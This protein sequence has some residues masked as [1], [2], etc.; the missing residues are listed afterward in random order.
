MKIGIDLRCLE[1]EKISGVGEYALEIVRN[2]LE[3][4]TENQYIIFSNSY[5]QKS[6]NFNFLKRYPR[7]QLKRF[8][9]PN[10]VLNL[11]LW[12]FGWPKLDRLVGGADIFFAPNINFLSVGRICKLVTT[13][14]DL[15]FERF[16]EF[17]SLKTRLWHYFF[18]NPRRIAKKAN[19]I[20]AVSRSTRN[21]LKELYKTKSEAISIIHHGISENYTVISRNNPKLLD[22][23]K[24]YSL[25]YKFILYLGNIEPR[26]N[27]QSIIE[28]YKKVRREHPDLEKHKLVLAGNIS[29]LC[30]NI[31]EK[32]KENIIAAGYVD[33]EDKPFIYNLAS[34]FVYL[35]LFEGFGLPVLEAMACG[36]PA[37]TSNNSSIP[38]VAGNAAILVDPSRPQEISEAIYSVLSGDKLYNEMRKRGIRQAKK[39]SWP[40][41]A[42]ETSGIFRKIIRS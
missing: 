33:Q 3:A 17:F 15:S 28:A 13:F 39:F 6:Q 8:R 25:P 20:I 32:E 12:Y 23:Q 30:Y 14:H 42:E 21:D 27:I 1:E 19:R 34:L 7:A 31:V 35:S 29:P 10:K 36:T 24:K 40:K 26:K 5:K 2:I 18:V 22:V 4:D 11:L 37:I 38:E 41:C 9:Y 16:P